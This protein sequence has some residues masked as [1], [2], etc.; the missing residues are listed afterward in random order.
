MMMAME[1]QK[2]KKRKKFTISKAEVVSFN[3]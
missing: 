2:N 1:S 3:S